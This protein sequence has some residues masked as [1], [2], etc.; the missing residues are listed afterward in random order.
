M[1]SLGVTIGSTYFSGMIAILALLL[2][3]NSVYGSEF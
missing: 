2:A 1:Y 3:F